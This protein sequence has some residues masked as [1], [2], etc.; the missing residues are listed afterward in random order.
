M[1][2]TLTLR[3]AV[4]CGWKGAIT[5][6]TRLYR[7]GEFAKTASVTLRTLRF[8]DKVGLLSPSQYTEA[9]YRLYSEAD[10]LTLQRILALKF[11]G[12]SLEEIKFC[13]RRS[14]GQLREALAQQRAMMQEKRSRLDKLI[15]A[16]EET[17]A[18]LAAGQCDWQSIARVIQMIQ[19]EQK[20]EW[21]KKYFNDEQI[22][23]MQ[24]LGYTSYSE[25]ALEKLRQGG[26]WTEEDQKRADEQWRYVA[27][28]ARRL[29]AV[30][31]DPAGEEAQALAKVKSDLLFAFTQGDPEITA[32]LGRFWDNF[33]TL[34][35]DERP[36]DASV[37]DAGDAG[38]KLLE[39]AMAL[40]AERRQSAGP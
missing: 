9:G 10:L 26:E 38:T 16:I 23:K 30:G 8:Y 5:L 27:A 6:K 32:G 12:F 11:L 17:E 7:T 35:K 15:K 19:M 21:V 1:P 22:Q 2:L 29:A 14:P 24:E 37:Y 28:E 40:Y 4:H 33:H 25:A 34:P 3:H 31:A 13:L 20:N 18:L 36:F 39:D